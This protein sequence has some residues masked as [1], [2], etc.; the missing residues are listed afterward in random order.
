V[1]RRRAFLEGEEGFG[2]VVTATPIREDVPFIV[3][4]KAI[5]E[6]YAR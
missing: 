1:P 5:L 2:G 6:F 3:D 4:E